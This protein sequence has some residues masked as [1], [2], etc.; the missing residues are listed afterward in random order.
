[1]NAEFKLTAKDD[2]A[3]KC[4]YCEKALDEVYY[5][6]KGLGLIT[7]KNLVYFCP[8]CLK[9]LGFAQSRMA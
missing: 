2:M 7:G 5:K 8:S 6:T 3:P 9:V 1:M 4:P